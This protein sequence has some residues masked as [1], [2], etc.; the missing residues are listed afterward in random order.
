MAGRARVAAV[1][2]L[3][4]AAPAALMVAALLA[5]AG[6]RRAG[7]GLGSAGVP[8]VLISVDTLRAD[9]L[10]AYG[11]AGLRTPNIDAL[12]SD[13]V[14]FQNAYSQVPLTLPSHT[15]LFTG[16]LPPQ[17]GVRDNL[18]YALGPEP[19][20]LAAFLKAHGYATGGAV[21]SIILSHATGVSRGFDF[22]EDNI[23]PTAASQSIS[24]VQ[25]NGDETQALLAEWVS[26]A[27]KGPF[28]AFLHLFEPHSPYEPPE[29]FRSRY[30]LPYDGEIARADEIVG[31]FVRFLKERDI[32]DRALIVF[33]SDH[34]E[35]LNDHGED[36]HGVLLYREAIHVPLM[37]KLPGARRRGGTVAAPVALVDVFP[38]IAALV[39]LPAPSGLAGA[40]FVAAMNGTEPPPA[41]RIYSETLYPRLHL[42]WSD[43][44][45]LIDSRDHYIQSPRPELYDVV[46]DPGEKTDLS[47]G[48]PPAFR[49][50]RAELLA[51]PRPL[52][53][54]GASDPEQVKKLASLGY[55]GGTSADLDAKNLPAPRDR[56]GAVA[57]LKAG[58]GAMHADRYAEAVEIFGKLLKT[59]PGMTDVWQMYGESCMK[60]G[61]E[62]E[63][64][65]ALQRAAK[66]SPYNPQVLMALSDYYFEIGNYAEARRHAEAAGHAG[67]TSPYDNLARIALAEG[68]LDEAEKQARAAL[69]KYPMRRIPHLILGRVLHDRHDYPAAL[70]E[71]ALAS[72]AHGEDTGLLQNLNYLKGD[73]LARLGRTAEAE[74][75]FRQEIA[76]F[77]NNTAARSSLAMLYA[78]EGRE[79]EA[80]QTLDALVRDVRSPDAYFAAI[81]TYEILGDP[82]AAAGLRAEQ[83]RL[84]PGAKERKEA[85]G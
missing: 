12:R 27:S 62:T 41:R 49:S 78:S 70:D 55:I 52:Q 15:A 59:E 77:P 50:M 46:A 8:V 1:A 36:E 7:G 17:N 71:I 80:R 3:M 21:S 31:H 44:A 53:A 20:T 68:N 45:S 61:R 42:G 81:R 38:S 25:R 29:P 18:G 11:Y 14:L 67:T 48:L 13:A 33:L 34:G 26:G 4:V 56:I 2:A 30:P 57:Q 51:M 40:S 28:F 43:L 69:E 58:F 47:G 54:P 63:A 16:L 9:H 72:R 85:G 5:F 19:A 82:H 6:C 22:W 79:A 75:A 35:G 65:A 24:R 60:L 84:F 66:L 83:R 32:Y 73:S 37:V 10:P 23:E 64:L 74:A 76:D 39:D